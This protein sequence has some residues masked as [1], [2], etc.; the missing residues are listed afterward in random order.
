[1]HYT[2]F[3]Q[4]VDALKAA[5]WK[6]TGDAQWEQIERMWDNLVDDRYHSWRTGYE[7]KVER[8]KNA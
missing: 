2:T 5:G 4:F 8:N 1:M 7:Q 6:D 3:E